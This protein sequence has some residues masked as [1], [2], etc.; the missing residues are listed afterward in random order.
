MSM[1]E[2]GV[3]PSLQLCMILSRGYSYGSLDSWPPETWLWDNQ[4][5]LF[6]DTAFTVL[7]YPATEIILLLKKDSLIHLTCIEPLLCVLPQNSSHRPEISVLVF[8]SVFLVQLITGVRA[9]SWESNS[10]AQIS[11]LLVSCEFREIIAS[12]CLGFLI[13]NGG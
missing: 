5:V 2:L 9:Q 4:G 12:L 7:C 11:V 3:I 13:S 10:L 1:E 8:S 6:Q